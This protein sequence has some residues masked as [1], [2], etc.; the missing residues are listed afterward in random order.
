MLIEQRLNPGM[1]LLKQK[2][3]LLLLF[4]SQLQ[5]FRKSSKFPASSIAA[6]GYAEAADALKAAVPIVLSCGRTGHS[7]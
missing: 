6:Y 4:R 7:E 1:V 3:D 5:I 2:P